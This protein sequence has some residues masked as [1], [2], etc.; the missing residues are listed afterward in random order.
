VDESA[1]RVLYALYSIARVMSL[2]TCPLIALLGVSGIFVVCRYYYGHGPCLG[3]SNS[4]S[5]TTNPP[6][7]ES[8]VL[9]LPYQRALPWHVQSSRTIYLSPAMLM[10]RYVH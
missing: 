5:G 1:L 3:L 9:T 6:L 2:L 4:T 10:A 8:C 7:L